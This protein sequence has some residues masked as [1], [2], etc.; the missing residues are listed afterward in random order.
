MNS[1]R[2][3]FLTRAAAG[4]TVLAAGSFTTTSALATGQRLA[5]PAAPSLTAFINATVIDVAT[6]RR[7]RH[8][9]VLISG[10]RI[11]GVGR[12]PVPRGAT[13]IDATGKY[14][15][16]GLAD[17]HVH[18]LGDERVSPPLYLANGL[19]TIREMSGTD[20]ML[21]DWRD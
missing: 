10:D 4:A 18:S 5:A 3:Q 16:P 21:Y 12:I 2:R 19:T 17:M 13:V 6:G 11:V 7:D 20:P 1:S 15:I 9:T 8:Q 14:V